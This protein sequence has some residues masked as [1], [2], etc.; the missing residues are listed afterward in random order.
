MAY[1]DMWWPRPS[2]PRPAK[3]GI[4]SRS[5]RGA[6]GESWWARRWIEVLEGFPIGARLGRGRSYARKGQVL[7]IEVE[8]GEVTARVQ[9]SRPTPYRVTVG[10]PT[11]SEAERRAV[12]RELAR[13]T[14]LAAGLLAGEM[15]P[16][17]E[18]VFLEAGSP[19]FPQ[20]VGDLETACSCPDWSNPCKHIAAVYYLVAEELDRNP[21]LLLRLRGFRRRDLVEA[22][23]GALGEAVGERV[24]SG[25]PA[26]SSEEREVGRGDHGQEP[27]GREPEATEAGPETGKA[28]REASTL[29]SEPRAFWD[30]VEE[31][32]KT[33]AEGGHGREGAAGEEAAGEDMPGEQAAGE[34]MAGDEAAGKE[35]ESDEDGREGDRKTAGTGAEARD[36]AGVHVRSLGRIPFWR[37]DDDPS[38]ILEEMCRKAV[39]LGLEILVGPEE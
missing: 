5:R 33:G 13:H 35:D 6:F 4:R 32:E 18:E 24:G 20:E 22:T 25:V 39:P 30:G 38:P 27:P 16:E 7:D 14:Q 19:L 9:G 29:P 15:P 28:A 17:L 11:L 2:K 1:R 8:P 26:G 36:A 21:F 10:L 37:G 23:G 3:G 12:A 31:E 34:A